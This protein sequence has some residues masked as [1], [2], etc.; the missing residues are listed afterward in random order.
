MLLDYWKLET[1]E[2]KRCAPGVRAE[3]CCSLLPAD[4]LAVLHRSPHFQVLDELPFVF[5]P[6]PVYLRMCEYA[7]ITELA[8]ERIMSVVLLIRY[9]VY[10]SLSHTTTQLLLLTSEVP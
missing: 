6:S 7:D 1:R 4:W 8:N 10:F 3:F 2:K 5:V 9:F